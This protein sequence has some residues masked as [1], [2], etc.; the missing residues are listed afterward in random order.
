MVS[1][2]FLFPAESVSVRIDLE[3]TM[4]LILPQTGHISIIKAPF[5][6]DA[7]NQLL[8]SFCSICKSFKIY[9][10]QN[11]IPLTNLFDIITFIKLFNTPILIL[12]GFCS[13]PMLP[14]SVL[15]LTLKA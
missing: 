3:M 14:D 15:M 6:Y 5:Q 1:I 13:M 2:F 10:Y 11:K 7:V 12:G 4:L 9:Q 8:N